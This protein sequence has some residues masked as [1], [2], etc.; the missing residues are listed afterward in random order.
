MKLDKLRT[1]EGGA[2]DESS[3]KKAEILKCNEY[4]KAACSYFTHFTFMYA[5]AK[6]RK[7]EHYIKELENLKIHEI[8]SI[9]C[10][11]PDESKL[12]E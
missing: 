9:F 2:I 1:R 5:Q 7:E 6:D 10:S 3:L 8:V 11:H 12:H 4:A